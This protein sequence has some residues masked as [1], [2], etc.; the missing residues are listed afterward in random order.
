MLVIPPPV[1][2]LGLRLRL[3]NEDEDEG[4]LDVMGKDCRPRTRTRT[5]TRQSPRPFSRTRTRTRTMEQL[6]FIGKRL[7]ADFRVA[8]L[9]I[10]I[11]CRQSLRQS[12]RQSFCTPRFR[13]ILRLL[14]LTRPLLPGY[15]PLP[16]T[17]PERE[18]KIK[19]KVKT[20]SWILLLIF[21]LICPERD[22]DKD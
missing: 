5:R 21:A 13:S 4:Q 2:R 19:I 18:T 7:L 8:S 22:E 20:R 12:S 15:H 16:A 6:E 9:N 3:R 10:F 11:Y 17:R 14:T 1:N